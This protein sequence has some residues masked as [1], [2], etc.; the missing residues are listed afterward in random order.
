MLRQE[1]RKEIQING[2]VVFAHYVTSP[3]QCKHASINA[4][5]E[6][7]KVV[8]RVQ[9]NREKNPLES[10]SIYSFAFVE[11]GDALIVFPVS[12]KYFNY[13]KNGVATVRV[14]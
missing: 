4:K 14:L 5:R 1:E 6:K 3:S 13:I 12:V 11:S 8:K 10:V 7:C 2:C 9:A